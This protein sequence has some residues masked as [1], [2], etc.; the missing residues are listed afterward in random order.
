MLFYSHDYLSNWFF[1]NLEVWIAV[2]S[3]EN[4]QYMI[5]TNTSVGLE[6]LEWLEYII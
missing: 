3:G 5:I 6:W 4:V 1:F 2:V